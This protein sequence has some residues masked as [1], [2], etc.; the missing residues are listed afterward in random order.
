ML[1]I[2]ITRKFGT[3]IPMTL[4]QHGNLIS[5]KKYDV[6]ELLRKLSQFINHRGTTVVDSTCGCQQGT[7]LIWLVNYLYKGNK[8][9]TELRAILQRESQNS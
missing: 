5:M 8:K 7:P 2:R 9:I 3:Y 4:R 6:Y 1:W